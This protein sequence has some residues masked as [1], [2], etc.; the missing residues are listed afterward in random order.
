MPKLCESRGVRGKVLLVNCTSSIAP[1]RVL[2]KG[3]C[4]TVRAAVPACDA[5]P[6]TVRQKWGQGGA[7]LGRGGAVRFVG[8]R[9]RASIWVLVRKGINRR[10]PSN[11]AGR[12][13]VALVRWCAP[14]TNF[15]KRA[16]GYWGR[17]ASTGMASRRG[18][19]AASSSSTQPL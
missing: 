11:T 8:R 5:L 10:P 13:L 17:G 15:V 3:A 1:C 7:V 4:P 2:R 19:D 6:P 16:W 18:R 14:P 9:A 12:T